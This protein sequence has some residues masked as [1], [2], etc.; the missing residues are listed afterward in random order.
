MNQLNNINHF[1]P[2]NWGSFIVG[3]IFAMFF[4]LFSAT[5]FGKIGGVILM[6]ILLHTCFTTAW[7]TSDCIFH[8]T[9]FGRK[10]KVLFN[11]IKYIEVKG[12][13]KAKRNFVVYLKNE[14]K[15]TFFG[16]DETD[17]LIDNIAK[18]NNI[19]LL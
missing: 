10:R 6:V 12:G 14:M 19:P 5:I 16:N 7:I 2:Y 8:K 3:G 1:T 15:I 9:F 17:L 18:Q 11:E 13:A 4:I